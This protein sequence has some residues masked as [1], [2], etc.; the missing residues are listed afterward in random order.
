MSTSITPDRTTAAPMRWWTTLR[1]RLMALLALAGTLP[2]GVVGLLGYRSAATALRADAGAD[3]ETLAFNAADKLDRNLFERYGDVQAFASSEAAQSL[4]PVRVGAWIDRMMKTYA[5][6]YDMMV[7]ADVQ[8]KVVAVSS[9]DSQGHPVETR[10]LLGRDVAQAEWFRETV[11]LGAGSDKTRVGDLAR[12]PLMVEAFG[13]GPK[14]HAMSFS[15]PI[16]AGG[17]VVGVWSNRFNWEVA[18]TILSEVKDQAQQG[19]RTV[20][21]VLVNKTGQELS[22]RESSGAIGARRLGGH[23]IVAAALGSG[24]RGNGEGAA[25]GDGLTVALIGYHHSTG[26]SN[27]AGLDWAVLAAQDLDAA[28]AAAAQ[29]RRTV[30]TV[31][32]LTAAG[33]IV[34]LVLAERKFFRP[35]QA[36]SD[37]LGQFHRAETDLRQRLPVGWSGEVGNLARGFNG[38]MDNLEHMIRSVLASGSQVTA[39]TSSIASG[40]RELEAT[41][42]EQ[43]AATNEVVASAQEI[44]ATSAELTRTMS[45]VAVRFDQASGSAERSQADLHQMGE[46]IRHLEEALELVMTK[47]DVINEKANAISSVVT[48][49][50]KVADQTNLLSL[51]AAIEAEKAGQYGQGFSVVARE[52]RRLAD[53][54][55][56]AT[57]D[58]E[59]MVRE[60]KHAVSSGVTTIDTFAADVHKAADVVRQVG[61]RL[62][63]IVA[64]VRTVAPE[65]ELVNKGVEAQSLGARQIAETMAQL[66]ATTK[67]TAHAIDDTRG[68]IEALD[69][70]AGGL[71]AEFARFGLDGLAN[72]GKTTASAPVGSGDGAAR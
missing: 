24:R 48:T 44:S 60:M 35:L 69:K 55:A 54:T 11:A 22:A 65:V 41:V 36:V 9:V 14:A 50:T 53:Q 7:V 18:L 57:L 6:I 16:V 34:F 10:A 43:V 62:V 37:M 68:A 8:G 23:P 20:D 25:L 42:T 45:N 56:L 4:E 46:S 31:A 30:L 70:A 19:G 27:Y 71:Q 12:D 61:T 63:E 2:L 66:S 40:T 21:L 5:P 29:I 1:F 28:M 72:A 13:E 26:Y 39:S 3:L 15:A 58:I 59:K 49:I 32:L 17:K 47:L 52:I 33:L 64:H 67:Q 38:V 51:N